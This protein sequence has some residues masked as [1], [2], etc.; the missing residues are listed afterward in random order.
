M[1]NCS[2]LPFSMRTSSL[3]FDFFSLISQMVIFIKY[4]DD[5][6]Y[7]IPR[8]YFTKFMCSLLH[9]HLSRVY[10]EII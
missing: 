10:Y 6:I 9:L 4:F 5:S 8:F 3:S 1:F 2:T 7:F